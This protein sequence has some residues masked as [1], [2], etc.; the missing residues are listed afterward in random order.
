M[1]YEQNSNGHNDL[2]NMHAQNGD[3]QNGTDKIKILQT[4]WCRLNFI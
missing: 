4:K 2:C 1:V 3:G